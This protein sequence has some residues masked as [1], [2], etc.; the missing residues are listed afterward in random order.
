MDE[1]DRDLYL[2]GVLCQRWLVDDSFRVIVDEKL[3]TDVK[4]YLSVSHR[5]AGVEARLC[6]NQATWLPEALEIPGANGKRIIEFSDYREISGV[7]FPIR[8]VIGSSGGGQQWVNAER[9]RGF[10]PADPDVFA[11]PPVG[12]GAKFDPAV[13]AKL[14][15]KLLNGR[16]L[17][18][19]PKVNG[20]DVPW[21]IVDTGNG[22][23]TS[24]TAAEA[25]RLDLPSFGGTNAIGA[26]T[27]KTRFRQV[28]RFTLGPADVANTV[29]CELPQEF[30][31]L[32]S[33][34]A[35]VQ[36]AGLIGW[37]FLFRAVVEF[38]YEAGVVNV[39]DP[40]TYRL[41]PGASWE[42]IHFNSR[43]P[44]VKGVFEGK[45][46][47]LF[48]LDT[49]HEAKLTMH[50]PAVKRL[51][52]LNGRETTARTFDGIGGQEV[53]RLGTATEFRV[54][55]RTIKSLNVGLAT[56]LSGLS[57]D[58]YTLGTFGLAALGSGRVVFD[59]PNSRIAFIPAK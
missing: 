30:A 24:M 1:A 20:K 15:T 37:D 52:L 22:A 7:K 41:S 50:A 43:M 17:L 18:A 45:H 38:D 13:S 25:D 31:D 56:E 19:K 40:A 8:V 33:R 29:L 3:T 28:D 54:L 9:G 23:L 35:G 26:R 44:C 47:G 51:D 14:E 46:E 11:A 4:V 53:V 58:P 27:V 32:V 10:H 16:I 21:F 55:G 48:M 36:V 49:G 6:V 12:I 42:P 2:F 34:K 5:D 59:Y 39:H 57:S